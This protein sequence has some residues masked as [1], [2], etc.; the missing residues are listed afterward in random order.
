MEAQISSRKIYYDY[1]MSY[2]HTPYLWKG[3]SQNIGLDSSSF[4]V[5]VLKGAGVLPGYFDS[6]CQHLYNILTS[7]PVG[8]D[9]QFGAI[10]FYGKS[11][12]EIYHCGVM[13]NDMF[14]LESGGGS[15]QMTELSISYEQDAR[16]RLRPKTYRKD[17]VAAVFPTYRFM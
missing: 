15:S 1:L 12:R 6:N 16:V 10:V 14:M 2:I 11:V 17:F 7:R 4:V 9:I 8:N 13:L 3:K 5:N